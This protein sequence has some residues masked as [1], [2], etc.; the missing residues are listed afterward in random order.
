MRKVFMAVGALLVALTIAV[1]PAFAGTVLVSGDQTPAAPNDPCIAGDPNSLGT[2]TMDGS[3][4]GCWYTDDF[5]FREQPSGNAEA[6]GHEHFV[7]CLDLGLDGSCTGDPG[8]TLS[9]SFQFSGRYDNVTF[10]EIRGRCHHPIVSGTG[11]F[12]DA[13]GVLHFKD[14][15]ATGIASY[16]GNVRL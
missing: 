13:S 3:L 9:F 8:G 7:G 10:A 5:S 1:A 16:T 2:F 4:I 11:A 12:A 14:D 6:T 15:V